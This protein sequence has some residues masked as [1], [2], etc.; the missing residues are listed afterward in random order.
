MLVSAVVVLRNSR[1]T[2]AV[3]I[4]HGKVSAAE[5]SNHSVLHVP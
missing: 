2:V 1:Q 4:A 3:P 5:V